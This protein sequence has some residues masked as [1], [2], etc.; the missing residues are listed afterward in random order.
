M[1]ICS[2]ASSGLQFDLIGLLRGRGGCGLRQRFCL[3]SRLVNQR[4]EGRFAP[5]LQIVEP[6]KGFLLGF[7]N[8]LLIEGEVDEIFGAVTEDFCRGKGG[9]DVGVFGGEV[10]GFFEVTHC[11]HSI[12]EGAGAVETPLGVGN[13]LGALAF[14]RRMRVQAVHDFFG[15]PLEF[16]HVFTGQD[17]DPT[18]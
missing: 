3:F 9:V 14:H 16:R 7:A 8:A 6:M 2:H 11:D 13:C 4:D 5:V 18:R 10:S 17:Y 12:F 15:E 1:T